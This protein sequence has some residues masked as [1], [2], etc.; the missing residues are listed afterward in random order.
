MTLL[1]TMWWLSI[2]SDDDF[3][4]LQLICELGGCSAVQ[5]WRRR[6]LNSWGTGSQL[7]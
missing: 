7:W 4:V 3:Y 2:E 1:M 5:A 6:D